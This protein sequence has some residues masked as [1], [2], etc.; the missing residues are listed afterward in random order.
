MDMQKLMK[1]IE[2]HK[3]LEDN[4]LQAKSKSKAPMRERKETKTNHPPPRL[5]R[6]YFNQGSH[7]RLKVVNTL[8]KEPC[9]ESWRKLKTSPI[10]SGQIRWVGMPPKKIITYFALIIKRG[11][12]L[13]RTVYVR[14][15]FAPAGESRTPEG[16]HNLGSSL[17]S[18]GTRGK[19][20]TGFSP[21]IGIVEVICATRISSLLG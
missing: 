3:R 12:T 4:Q 18:R 8:Y 10:S 13:R 17:T 1:Q 14:G 21:H 16:I 15:S 11:V 6:D 2:E 20:I 19:W 7:S 5:R 9:L